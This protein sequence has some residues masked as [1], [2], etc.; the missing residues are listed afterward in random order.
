[1]IDVEGKLEAVGRVAERKM[2]RFGNGKVAE[3]FVFASLV[4]CVGA[5]AIVG[6]LE[7]GLQGVHKIL[8]TKALLDGFSAIFFTST[9]GI[10]VALSAIPVF[11]YQGS[12]AV[13]AVWLSSV[14]SEPIIAVMSATGGVLIMG[15]ALNVMEI[16]KVNVGNLLPAIFVAAVV[17]WIAMYYGV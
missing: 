15:I 4:Y 1:L 14:L 12:I 5:M 10:G 2:S 6:A 9:L 3:A 16:K 11:L 8:Y 17:K 13:L 7:S